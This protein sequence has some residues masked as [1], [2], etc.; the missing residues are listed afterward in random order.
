MLIADAGEKFV[1]RLIKRSPELGVIMDGDTIASVKPAESLWGY[2]YHAHMIPPFCP[3][4]AL[5][6]GYGGGQV[7]ELIRR[8]WGPV[9]IT[10]VDLVPCDEYLEHKMFTGDADE[11]IHDCTRGLIKTRF[12]YV[13]VDLFA[14]G[15]VPDFVF[16]DGTARRLRQ[17][18]KTLLCVNAMMEDFERLR[19]LHEAGFEFHRHAQVFGNIVSYWGA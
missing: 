4:E 14:N 17:M 18:T 2:T 12:D 10:G 19:N 6:L 16:K 15:Q 11:F 1:E 8:A 5:I 13:A 3:S 9:K 7:A